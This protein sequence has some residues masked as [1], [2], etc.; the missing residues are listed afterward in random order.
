[1]MPAVLYLAPSPSL[2]D[3]GLRL[4]R[5]GPCCFSSWMLAT[6]SSPM[7]RST[8]TRRRTWRC[9]SGRTRGN[10]ITQHNYSCNS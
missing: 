10:Q 5:S 1:M 8:S 3:T 2:E 9:P 6:P 7:A 4:T